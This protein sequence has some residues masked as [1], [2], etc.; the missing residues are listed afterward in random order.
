VALRVTL[1]PLTTAEG[2]RRGAFPPYGR[3]QAGGLC[4]YEDMADTEVRP[5]MINS[6]GRLF[7][8]CSW[9]LG[10]RYCLSTQRKWQATQ[11]SGADSR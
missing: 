10:V 2:G 7:F 3:S 9:R 5:T 4:H 11:W 1:S 8:I 6:R